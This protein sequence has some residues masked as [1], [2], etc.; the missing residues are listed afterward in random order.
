[1]EELCETYSYPQPKPCFECGKNVMIRHFLPAQGP[2]GTGQYATYLC[3]EHSGYDVPIKSWQ[4]RQ[5][6]DYDTKEQK[7][8][9]EKWNN[10]SSDPLF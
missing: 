10:N 5:W 8:Q 7:E 9:E 2:C 6:T 3:T 4:Y 1:M